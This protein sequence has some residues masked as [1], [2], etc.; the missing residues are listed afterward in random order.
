[1]DSP[2]P[3]STLPSLPL[4]STPKSDLASWVGSR[5]GWVDVAASGCCSDEE[6]SDVPPVGKDVIKVPVP[7]LTPKHGGKKGRGGRSSLQPGR[8]KM[9]FDLDP[10]NAAATRLAFGLGVSRSKG[11]HAKVT[12]SHTAFPSAKVTSSHPANHATDAPAKVG[13]SSWT[14]LS[15]ASQFIN[16]NHATVVPSISGGSSWSPPSA[17]SQFITVMSFDTHL[18]IRGVLLWMFGCPVLVPFFTFG[19]LGLVPC[20][21][22]LH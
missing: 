7:V 20:S 21:P 18:F 4:S 11:S 10:K 1:M 8:S 2:S 5:K 17:S 3:A 13:G 15:T 22:V 6:L 16:A 14:P 9:P 12:G 19:K